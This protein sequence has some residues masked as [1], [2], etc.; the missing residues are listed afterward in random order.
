MRFSSFRPIIL[1]MFTSAALACA[2]TPRTEKREVLPPA[3]LVRVASFDI[4]RSASRSVTQVDITYEI[5][6]RADGSPDFA[7]L[8]V[9]GKGAS[10]VRNSLMEWIAAS[11]VEPS[12][13][14][15]IHVT[16]LYK[17]GIRSSVRRM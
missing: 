14:N 10:E 15:G 3:R 7:T 12:K 9:R 11:S 17:G 8:T 13:R 16:S 6:I 5:V 2:S 1:A 4:V